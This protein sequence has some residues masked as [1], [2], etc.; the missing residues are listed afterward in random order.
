MRDLVKCSK[1]HATGIV[2]FFPFSKA[3]F[4]RKSSFTSAL[5]IHYHKPFFKTLVCNIKAILYPKSSS[6]VR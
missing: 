5:K 2:K 1:M 3:L 6:F 4:S